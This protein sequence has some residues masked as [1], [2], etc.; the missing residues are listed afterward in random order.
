MVLETWSLRCLKSMKLLYVGFYSNIASLRRA[1]F[2]WTINIH[3]GK[4]NDFHELFF[5]IPAYIYSFRDS[6]V[7]EFRKA[8]YHAPL[9]MILLFLP[10]NTFSQLQCFSFMFEIFQLLVYAF[11]V[12]KELPVLYVFRNLVFLLWILKLFF[13]KNITIIKRDEWNA[14]KL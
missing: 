6:L 9:Y 2:F 8:N 14:V 11:L 4:T 3:C 5:K 1:E 12:S 7:W 10:F 13:Q